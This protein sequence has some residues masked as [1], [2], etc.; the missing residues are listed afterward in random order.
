MTRSRILTK[1]SALV[2]LSPQAKD[3][4]SMSTEQDDRSSHLDEPP[5]AELPLMDELVTASAL[6]TITMAKA[7]TL[8][9]LSP[10]AALM[11]DALGRVVLANEQAATLFGYSHHELDGQPLEVLL[12]KRFH[13]AHVAHRRTYVTMPRPRPMGVG[14]DLVGRRKD[15]SEFP[16]DIS[17]RPVFLKQALHMVGAIRDVTAQ[18]LLERERERLAERLVLQSTLI[19]LAHDAILVRDPISRVLSWNRGAEALYGWSEQEALGRVSHLLLKTRF[20]TSRTALEA[21]LESE[22]QWEGELLH[23]RRDG[24]VITIESRQV[25]IRDE[26]GAATAILEINRDITQRRKGEQAQTAVHLETLAQ[27]TFLQQLLDSL[28]SSIYVVHG[29]DARLVL[30]NHVAASTW[31]AEWSAG[32]PMRAFLEEHSIRIIEASGRALPPE[33]WATMRALLSGETV[34]QQQEIIRQPGGTSLPILV[35]AVPLTSPHWRSLGVPDEPGI[36]PPPRNGEPL[37]LVIHQ[38]IRLLKEVDY[39]KDEFISIA[40]HELRQP[41]TVLKVALGTLMLQTARGHGTPLA[42]W[43]QEMLQDLE[44]AT[45]RL[46]TLT[47]D[48]LDVSRLQAGQLVLQRAP[49]NLVFL[50]QRLVERFQKTTT[51]HQLAFHPE[52]PTLEAE[53]DPQRMEQV[54]SNLLTN[55]I[56][57]SPQGGSIVVTV[58]KDDADHAVEIRVQDDGMGIPLHQQ[59]RIFGRFM[60]ADNAQAAGIS[61][62]GLGLYLCRALVEQHA[63]R[64]WFESEEGEGTTF[65]VTL[66]PVA[67]DHGA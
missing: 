58:G 3:D 11:I 37:A 63:G 21:L 14:F 10:D 31:G 51:R 67:P 61:G 28:P 43:Q 39:A 20:P 56:K 33:A 50:V 6:P 5:R 64:L 32:Q 13:A 42:E 48:L 62:T 18:R 46:S 36:S 54:L 66:P 47:E 26:R 17:L 24:S 65:F 7:R 4:F 15:G 34:L 19:N 59:A 45:D 35:N 49:T 29:T 27:R 52:Q 55:A 16:V 53:I 44:Q 9:D 60:R 40:A 30:A 2:G 41:L 38:D 12:P 23:T 1:E 25:L 22:G 8:L 57:Y